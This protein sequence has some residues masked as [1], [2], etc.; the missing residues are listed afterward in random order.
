M[1]SKDKKSEHKNVTKDP[2]TP[3]VKAPAT[4]NEKVPANASLELITR[5]F[6]N[7]ERGNMRLAMTSF[8]NGVKM[9]LREKDAASYSAILNLCKQKQKFLTPKTM[10]Q[11]AN[12]FDKADTALLETVMT[13]M[14]LLATGKHQNSRLSADHIRVITKSDHFTNWVVKES[15]K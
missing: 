1:I 5:Y 10:L 13:V 15:K 9:A 4:A 7:L 2:A 6:V 8:L 3:P 14:Y 11:E 12:T